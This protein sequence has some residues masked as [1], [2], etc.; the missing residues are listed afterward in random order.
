MERFAVG[1]G[2]TTEGSE[3]PQCLGIPLSARVRRGRYNV[4]ILT[5][6]SVG[7]PWSQRE[8]KGYKET[9]VFWGSL[10]L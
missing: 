6:P 4:G 3:D 1:C 7:S 2:E 10:G 8:R 5:P 9:W